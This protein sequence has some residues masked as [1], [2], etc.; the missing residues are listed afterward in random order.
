MDDKYML[1]APWPE[2]EQPQSENDMDLLDGDTN[3]QSEPLSTEQPSSNDEIDIWDG[4][5]KQDSSSLLDSK[6][7]N[8]G[9]GAEPC[10]MEGQQFSLS[11][12]RNTQSQ[13]V[14]CFM[15]YLQP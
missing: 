5:T 3:M 15:Q 8:S 10:N 14:V 1:S 13:L 7:C 9:S 11:F 6:L 4:K 2:N 12:S